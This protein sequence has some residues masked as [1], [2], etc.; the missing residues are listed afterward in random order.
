MRSY[1]VMSG[2]KNNL[3]VLLC[4]APQF[5]LAATA[6]NSN[7]PIERGDYRQAV[8]DLLQK[9]NDARESGMKNEQAA[10]LSNIG[11]AYDKLGRYADAES[12]LKK[13][14]QMWMALGQTH[15]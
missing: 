1:S 11:L 7:E 9:V 14:R 2:L 8:D 12:S 10:L 13:S 4:I 5:I 15:T 6:I 3:Q